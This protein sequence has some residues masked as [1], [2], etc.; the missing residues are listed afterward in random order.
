MYMC[1]DQELVP[2]AVCRQ[3]AD[4]INK[5]VLK[6][7][8]VGGAETGKSTILS[9]LARKVSDCVVKFG[10]DSTQSGKEGVRKTLAS[11]ADGHGVLVIDDVDALTRAMQEE[12][13]WLLANN[14][15]ARV[16]MA[17]AESGINQ[18]LYRCA[19]RVPLP[20]LDEERFMKLVKR[21]CLRN[22]SYDV[23]SSTVWNASRGDFSSPRTTANRIWS[24]HLTNTTNCTLGGP[25]HFIEACIDGDITAAFQAA[26]TL[27]DMGSSVTELAEKVQ[28]HL[29]GMDFKST[30]LDVVSELLVR[31]IV[32]SVS[33]Y[34]DEISLALLAHD[35]CQFFRQHI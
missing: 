34:G 32:T 28:H 13:A 20:D 15:K 12:L 35:L 17:G 1:C 8:I 19:V 30:E 24:G 16:L 2:A 25:D 27:T 21:I 9:D 6:V 26:K 3:I 18:S 29:E 14:P 4:C 11:V 22:Y 31:F 33:E 5:K 23:T 7:L 10:D